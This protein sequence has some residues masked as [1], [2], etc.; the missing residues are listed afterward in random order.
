L[1][2]A[3][4][5]SG[6]AGASMAWK[7]FP[8]WTADDRR[9][10]G[11]SNSQQPDNDARP[12][13]KP[14]TPGFHR[15][16]RVSGVH[17]SEAGTH[18]AGESQLARRGSDGMAGG[19]RILCPPLDHQPGSSPAISETRNAGKRLRMERASTR[20]GAFAAGSPRDWFVRKQRDRSATGYRNPASES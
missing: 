9:R 3:A 7:R 18:Y 5:G 6:G 17:A 1:R 13:P 15:L 8:E 19:R 2:D 11:A 16:T 20:G 4:S 14:G 12:S 10:D